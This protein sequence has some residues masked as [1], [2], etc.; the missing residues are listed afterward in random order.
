MSYVR[1]VELIAMS[2]VTAIALSA[3]VFVAGAVVRIGYHAVM[4]EIDEWQY[5]RRSK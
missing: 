5:R 1:V 2:S 4:E 3:A